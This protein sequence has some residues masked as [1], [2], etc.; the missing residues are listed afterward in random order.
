MMVRIF[1]RWIANIFLWQENRLIRR[2]DR[3]INVGESQKRY[4]NRIT[5]KPISVIMNCKPLQSLEYQPPDNQ[6]NFV[7]LYIGGLH[8]VRGLRML[9]QAVKEL[10]GVRCLI[11][12]IGQ[13]GYV[14]ALK[15]ECS[16]TSNVTFLG[17]VP[18]DEVIPLTMKADAIFCMFN[19]RDPNS[20]IGTPNK[21]F[22]AMACGRPIIC[23]RGTYSGELTEQEEVGL[24]VEYTEQALKEAIIKLRDNPGLRERLGRNALKAALTKYNWHKQEEKLIELYKSLQHDLL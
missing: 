7:L 1:P 5:N 3:I 18:F 13:P 4:F 24:A 11:G 9:V 8:Q 6:G 19:P 22:E 10:P 17:R 12:G 23:T 20:L 21:L 2:V 14:R 15:E 16:N